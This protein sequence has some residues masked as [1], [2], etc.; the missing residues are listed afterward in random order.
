MLKPFLRRLA[1]GLDLSRAESEKAMSL[2]MDG[3]ATPAQIGA[4]V[5]GLRLK[6]ETI[7]EVAGCAAA[8][9]A[10]AVQVEAPAGPVLDTCGTGGDGAS[11]FNI[12]TA[13][14][15]VA[16][17]AGATVAKHGNRAV[18][19]ACGSADV[20]EALGVVLSIGPAGVARC[21]RE[22]GIGFLFA[23]NHHAAM[24]HAAGPRKEIGIRTVFNILGPLSNPAGARRQLL[25]VYAP[26]MVPLMAHVL[27]GLGSERALVVH[28]R[29]GLDELS[30]A[31]PTLVAEL[32]DGQVTT[33]EVTPEETG[34][35]RHPG[36]S[37]AGGGAA[38]NAGLIRGIFEGRVT[39]APRDVVLLNAGG[40]LLASGQAVDLADGVNRARRALD[41]GSA[42]ET[43]QRLAVLT[44]ELTAR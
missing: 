31:G 20:M 29:E 16:A 41:D 2:I 3:D 33:R 25:G 40:A 18:S 17:A 21:L 4:F 38:E 12:S 39:G 8:M 14:A 13:A 30:I 10:R 15:F 35:R 36:A 19:S 23:P 22:V 34:L 27:A 24:R 44:T 42:A 26:E 11:T 37:L 6:G 5:F 7:D 1:Q 28:G 32:A 9:R 43:L